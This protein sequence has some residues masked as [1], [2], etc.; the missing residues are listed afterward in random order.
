MNRPPKRFDPRWG[1]LLLWTAF[2]LG[3]LGL[4]RLSGG[5]IREYL[6][7]RW[8][9]T[10]HVP[11]APVDDYR[12][13]V[14]KSEHRLVVHAGDREVK[15]FRAAI[16]EHGPAPRKTWEDE[17]TPEGIFMIASM[18]Y[19]SRFGPRQMLLETT[20]QSLA[21]YELQYGADGRR[22][23]EAWSEGHGPLDTIWEVYAFNEGNPG[24][25]IW[26]DILIH[27]GGSDR[28]WTWGCI[29]LDDA[30]VIELFEI[31][32]G[33]RAGGLGVAVEIR[34]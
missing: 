27:G 1:I 6:V 24:Y 5:H 13:V 32:R 16:S 19:E 25:P 22:R 29:A 30:D 15:A 33:S 34:P 2:L 12:I 8:M 7:W 20:A 31:L 28:D 4:Y 26:N 9:V 11:V 14:T 18:Q 3:G 23:L 21:D 17:L 10:F